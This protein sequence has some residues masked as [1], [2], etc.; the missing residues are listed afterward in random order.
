MAGETRGTRETGAKSLDSN[1]IAERIKQ[2]RTRFDE[3]RGRL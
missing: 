2:M 3:F 1:G